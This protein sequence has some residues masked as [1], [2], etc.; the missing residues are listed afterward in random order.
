VR[1]NLF[2]F[3]PCLA[4]LLAACRGGP[5]SPDV[6]ATSRLGEIR[7]ADLDAYVLSQPEGRRGPGPDQDARAWRRTLIEEMLAWR[8]LEA[9]GVSKRL[10]EDKQVAATLSQ[11]VDDLLVA[12]VRERRVAA[13]PALTDAEIRKYYD[14][15][16][17]EVGHSGQIRLRHIFR[18]VDRDAPRET[19]EK[20]RREME[21]LLREIR[22][23]ASFEELART[24]SDSETGPQ[25]GLIGRMN[26]GD[27][28]ASV[29]RIVWKLG[30]GQ[31]SDVVGTP[32][33][34]HIFRVDNKIAPYQMDFAEAL[35]RLRKRLGIEAG[36]RTL[37]DQVGELVKSSGAVYQPE[38]VADADPEAVLFSFGSEKLTRAGWDAVLARWSF[39]AQRAA[40][41]RDL[42]DSYVG[43]RLRL[44]EARRL[45]LE[46]D[47]AVATR[48]ADMRRDMTIRLAQQE[49]LK[50]ALRQKEKTLAA[51]YQANEARFM[52]PKLH[53]LRLITLA[54]PETGVD[55][56]VFERLKA[57]ASEIRA[58]KVSFEDQAR[59]ISTD[60]S[61]ARGGDLGFVRID[62]LGEWAG[63]R[64]FAKVEKVAV[65][66]VT[67]PILVERY[68][69]RKLTY[70][71]ESYML[72][73]VE[74]VQEPQPRPY[75]EAR[76]AVAEEY[77]ARDPDG[78]AAS[79]RQDVLRSIGARVFDQNL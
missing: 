38:L 14:S 67:E 33:G 13:Q 15:H 24:R 2:A 71:R 22:N 76:D 45:R 37:K 63:P 64:A 41:M 53:H 23:G 1:S 51:F 79:V 17:K 4:V 54:F 49:R 39:P 43:D 62:A 12:T 26:H 25:G 42:L 35:P 40:P 77:L 73:R 16:P 10:L 28:G 74:A 69:R 8:A 75:A 44:W 9:E 68:D 3:V 31:V 29:E 61:A 20:A 6:L 18:R 72:L 19:R 57:L 58:G 78:V 66:E 70:E 50:E 65:G 59:K 60:A 11:Q 48:I 5:A 56:A 52:T 7:K 27:L 46:Q 21:E 47:P 36:E 32:V 55:Y 30:E 34:F